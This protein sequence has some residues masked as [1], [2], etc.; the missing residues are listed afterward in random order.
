MPQPPILADQ[1]QIEPGSSGSRLVRRAADGSLE[2][3][4]PLNPSGITVSQLAGLQAVTNV[5]VVGKAGT[6]AQ[7]TTVQAALNAVPANSTRINPY[8][9][10]V[11]PGVY[12]EDLTVNRDGVHIIGIGRPILQ[13]ALEATPNA[14]GN[15]H[16]LTVAA[17]EGTIPL[18][19]HLENFTI[20]NAHDDKAA[21]RVVGGAASTLLTDGL[22][23]RNCF[24]EG[25]AAG[26]NYPLWAST[27]GAVFLNDCSCTGANN[28]ETVLI[29]EMSSCVLK[30]VAMASAFSFRYEVGQPEPSGGPGYLY[31]ARCTDFGVDT[32]LIPAVSIDCD[33]DGT[34]E[35]RQV[36]MSLASRIQ[37][38]GGESHSAE[39]C[40]LGVLSLLETPTLLASK[41]RFQS[42]LAANAN[43]KLQRDVITGTAVFAGDATKAVTFD[44]PLQ[45]GN[46]Y[47]VQVELPSRPVND[48]TA[49]VTGKTT[50]GFSINFQ[51]AQ[52]FTVG[53]RITRA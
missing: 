16:T 47:D 2:F 27:A 39:D 8:L 25:N 46:T 32:N 22:R 21:V 33:G 53:W 30:A 37:Y 43:A 15:A 51:T 9:I 18:T 7:Y 31:I 41:T 52:T 19:V 35:L 48:E 50:T 29:E 3:V 14:V 49:W 34:S 28:L 44:V 17:G 24:L 45:T 13:S 10:L 40:S 38:S 11:M 26:G 20:T 5:S 36:T 42:I 12:T 23:L 4:D 1:L 6:G